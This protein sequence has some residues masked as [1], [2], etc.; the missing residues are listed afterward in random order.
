M[1]GFEELA[2]LATF[3]PVSSWPGARAQETES[4]PFTA[5]WGDTVALLVKELSMLEAEQVVVEV[6][7]L[8]EQ[9]L[10]L[11]G[12]PRAN[13]RPGRGVVVSFGSKH[14]PLRYACD[15]FEA[16]SWRRRLDDWQHNMRAIALGLEAL[17]KVER[18]GIAQRGEQYRGYL[19]LEAGGGESTGMTLSDA[20]EWMA[21]HLED[22]LSLIHI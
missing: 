4:S 13:S 6:D 19:A 21:E 10:R 17:R 22:V 11:D 3:R 20:A 15:R 7:G 9:D 2:A 1:S 12:L 18:Y 14:G 5:G 16:A 8:R